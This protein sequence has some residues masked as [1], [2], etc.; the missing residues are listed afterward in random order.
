MG[1]LLRD[2]AGPWWDDT[3]TEDVRE[4]RDDILRQAMLDA[5]DELTK[6]QALDPEAWTWGHLHQLDLHHSTLGESGVGVLERLFNRDGF[7]VGGGSSIVDATGWDA[8]QGYGVTAAPSMR[9]VVSL[10]DFDRSRYIN[11]TGVSGHPGSSHYGDQTELFVNGDYLPW[12]F[13]RDAVVAAGQDTLVL[14]PAAD[15]D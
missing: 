9:M 4:S 5:R 2:P 15:P 10:A 12:A 7:D 3:Q 11:L 14:T 8:A 1:D 13:S 6:R